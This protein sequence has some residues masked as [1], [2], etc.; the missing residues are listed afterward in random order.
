MRQQRVQGD[1]QDGVG[2]LLELLDDAYAVDDGVGARLL[3]SGRDGLEAQSVDATEQ[4]RFGHAGVLRKLAPRPVAIEE[5]GRR[6][7]ASAEDLED[8]VA[9]HAFAAE[10]EHPHGCFS[11][12]RRSVTGSCAIQAMYSSSPSSSPTL[13]VKPK[14]AFAAAVEA[15]L[16]R[17]SPGRGGASSTPT[18][19]LARRCII[20]ARSLIVTRV[21]L[22]TL[23]A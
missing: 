20:A 11:P 16:S 23:N 12:R 10:D 3:E 22:P 17:T 6:V 18:S 1:R 21:E 19:R 9:Q 13:G 8:L 14:A 7:E 2:R 4:P 5:R 15:R